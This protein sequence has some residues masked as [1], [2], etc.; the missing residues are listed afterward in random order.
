LAFLLLFSSTMAVSSAH[1]QS[2]DIGRGTP[3]HPCALCL[4]TD[5]QITLS[6]VSPPSARDSAVMIGVVAPL[7]SAIPAS[8]DYRLSPSRAPPV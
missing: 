1:K 4:F 3:S 8:M 5:G 2:H 6:D 7:H